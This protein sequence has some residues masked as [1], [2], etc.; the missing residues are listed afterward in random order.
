MEPGKGIQME[1]AQA[2]DAAAEREAWF[3][4]SG[5]AE[6][7]HNMLRQGP[8]ADRKP[9]IDQQIERMYALISAPTP[10]RCREN[11]EADSLLGA[12]D[13]FA[14]LARL[15]IKFGGEVADLSQPGAVWFIAKVGRG[16]APD[17]G[18][19]LDTIEPSD[20]LIRH[21]A[22]LA[23]KLEKLLIKHAENHGAVPLSTTPPP[24]APSPKRSL[25]DCWVSLFALPPS[26]LQHVEAALC[27]ARIRPRSDRIKRALL[28]G[29]FLAALAVSSVCAALLFFR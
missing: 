23:G 6:Q 9:V 27:A 11:S 8:G 17:T 22:A 15:F 24:P 13:A 2:I 14:T 19:S 12:L 18:Q 7:L 28:W 16:A 21:A 26:A 25:T 1:K 3:V 29:M 10:S 20:H 5:Y 4:L